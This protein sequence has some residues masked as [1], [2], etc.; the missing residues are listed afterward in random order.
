MVSIITHIGYGVPSGPKQ[1]AESI[2]ASPTTY[3]KV[4]DP[5]LVPHGLREPLVYDTK[6]PVKT[7]ILVNMIM[8]G[9]E[10]QSHTALLF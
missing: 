9:W 10:I 5:L 7:K 6:Q 2:R 1:L 8:V 3:S 4:G